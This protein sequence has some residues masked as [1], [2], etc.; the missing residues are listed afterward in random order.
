MFSLSPKDDKF[1]DLFIENSETIY[2][3]A[4]LFRDFAIDMSDP[5]QKL[6]AIKDK[7]KESDNQQHNI[8]SELNKTFITPFDREDIYSISKKMDDI[9]DFIEASASRFVMF[10]VTKV[11]DDIYPLIDLVVK[12]CKDIIELMKQFKHMRNNEKLSEIIIEINKFEEEGDRV[13]REVVRKLFVADIPIIDVIKWREIFQC[14]ENTIDACE[15]VANIIEGVA[16]KN[17]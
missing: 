6:K 7:E 13:F 9:V 2:E 15:T 16:M 17:A 10:N 3:T 14:V 8:L 1:F 11:T 5:E 4:L 12:A